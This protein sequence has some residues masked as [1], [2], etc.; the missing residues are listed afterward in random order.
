[1]IQLN[2]KGKLLL[3][4]VLYFCLFGIMCFMHC[5]PI[6]ALLFQRTLHLHP[7]YLHTHKQRERERQ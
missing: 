5:L 4:L 2:Y 7:R 1:M 6:Y 3:I